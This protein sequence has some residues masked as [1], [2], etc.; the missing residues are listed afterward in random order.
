MELPSE[1]SLRWIVSRYAGLTARHGASIGTPD[2]VQ[3]TGD[4]FP[5]AFTPSGEAVAQLLR[6]VLEY[7]PVRDGLDVRLRFLEDSDGAAGGGCGTGSC[8][9][10]GS[11]KGGS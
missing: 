9:T 8:G 5:D 2:L 4:Y 3:P 7:A 10:G 11:A 1:D 6:R